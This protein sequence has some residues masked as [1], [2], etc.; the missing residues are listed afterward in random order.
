[1]QPKK[2]NVPSNVPSNV[3]KDVPSDVPSDTKTNS[4]LKE[5][6]TKGEFDKMGE[7]INPKKKEE[8]DQNECGGCGEKFSGKPK[9]CPHCGVEFE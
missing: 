1:M 7:K 3:P 8:E 4:F 6:N 2:D 9:F 5:I